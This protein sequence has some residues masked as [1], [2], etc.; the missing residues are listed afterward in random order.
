M[1][2]QAIALVIL[3]VLMGAAFLYCDVFLADAPSEPLPAALSDEIVFSPAPGFYDESI[4]VSLSCER[5]GAAI[6]YT[7]NGADPDEYSIRYVREIEK[8]AIGPSYCFCVKARVL[9]PSGEWSKTSTATYFIGK[10]ARERFDLPVVFLSGDPAGLFGYEN[11][12]LVAGKLRDD[13]QKFNP[14]ENAISISPAGYNLR[15]MKSEREVT[16]QLYA[17]DGTFLLSQQLGI[18]PF[19][20]YSRARKLKSL[21]LFPRYSYDEVNE[22]DYP[23]FGPDYSSDGQNRLITAY[24]RL[25]LH[26]SGNDN[27]NGMIK[28]AFFQRLARDA[29]FPDTTLCT[30]VSVYVNAEYYGFMWIMDSYSDEYFKDHFGEFPGRFEVVSGPENKKPDARY[31]SDTLPQYA[32]DDYNNMYQRYY[33][34]DLTDDETY[35]ALCR[36]LDVENYLFYYAVNCAINNNDWPYNNHKAF[37]YYRAAGE[38]YVEGTVFDGRWRFLIHDVDNT[39][40]ANGDILNVYLLNEKASRFSRLFTGLMEREDCRTFFIEKC[41]EIVNGAFSEEHQLAVLDELVALRD[42]ELS[43]H[44]ENSPYNATTRENVDLTIRTMAENAKKRLTFMIRDLNAAFSVG[45]NGYQVNVEPCGHA[46]FLVG[47]YACDSFSGT[48]IVGFGFTVRPVVEVGYRFE[49]WLVNGR[50]VTDEVLKT[51]GNAGNLTVSAVVSKVEEMPLILLEISS[52]GSENDYVVLFNPND[53]EVSTLGY[54]LSDREDRPGRLTLPSR[55]V[56]AG[57]TLKIYGNNNIDFASLRQIV[58]P[59]NLKKGETLLFSYRGELLERVL[60]PDL[61]QGNLYRKNLKNGQFYEVT[62]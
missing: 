52:A 43:F 26:S 56:G 3:V 44:L 22:V 35:A 29:G 8:K 17:P 9:F 39:L 12:I 58:A 14:E 53:H 32:Y 16:F 36:E 21:K 47:D 20:A 41:L 15:G 2:K 23:F 24:R 13:F 62:P 33:R 4:S 57:E 46:S 40:A 50:K 42:K 1:K 10:D 61:A 19:G 34:A 18:R 27:G 6:Y 25:V 38:E 45:K 55:K 7:T 54:M 48:Y 49:H 5:E 51:D 11:G 30:P 37:R 59:F 28:N 60:I 31:E